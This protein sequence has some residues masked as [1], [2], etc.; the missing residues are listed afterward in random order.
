MEIAAP[1]VRAE[2]EQQT[3]GFN[4]QAR[5]FPQYRER[6]PVASHEIQDLQNAYQLQNEAIM[7]R[8]QEAAKYREEHPDEPIEPF[9]PSGASA[10]F[11]GAA[12]GMK[13]GGVGYAYASTE[14][15][16]LRRSDG[17]FELPRVFSETLPSFD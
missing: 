10:V 7:K 11:S 13:L 2:V 16:D 14:P 15:E 3:A 4:H 17:R 12:H 6:A 8:I 9:Q 5:L 1:K